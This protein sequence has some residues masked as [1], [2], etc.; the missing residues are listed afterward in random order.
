MLDSIAANGLGPGGFEF[1]RVHS[2]VTA[3]EQR[4]D[5][6][7]ELLHEINDKMDQVRMELARITGGNERASKMAAV[8]VSVIAAFAGLGGFV[9]AFI[10]H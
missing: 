1:G 6:Q 4:A 2:R 9:L 8:G 7:S 5:E 10:K 3:L